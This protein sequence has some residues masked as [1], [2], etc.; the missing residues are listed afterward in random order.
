MSVRALLVTR[1]GKVNLSAGP[2]GG[3][4]HLVQAV[5]LELAKLG[6]VISRALR[7]RLI[8]LPTSTLASEQ[9]WICDTLAA[10]LGANQKHTPLFRKFPDGVPTDTFALWLDK[11][12]A[13]YLQQPNQPC[14]SCGAI[15]STHVLKPCCDVVCEVCF[16]G[17]NYSRCPVCE[18]AVEPGQPFFKPGADFRVLSDA[19]KITFK[20]LDLCEDVDA[21]ARRL[22]QSLLA[23]PQAMNPDDV[24]ALR[25]LVAEY[26]AVVLSWLPEKIPVRENRAHVFGHLMQ[27]QPPLMVLAAAKPHLGTATDILRVLAAY[28]GADPSLQATA[29]AA[30]VTEASRARWSAKSLTTADTMRA[31]YAKNRRWFKVLPDVTVPIQSALFKV[32][33]LSRALRRALLELLESMRPEAVVADMLRHPALWVHLG[34]LLHPFE[35]TKRFPNTARAFAVVRG[36]RG[37]L[38]EA[39]GQPIAEHPDYQRSADGRI[40]FISFN[41]RTSTLI[42]SQDGPALGRHLSARPG[43]LAR[44]LDLALRLSDEAGQAQVAERFRSKLSQ[45][46]TPVLMTLSTGLPQRHKKWPIRVFFPKG[47]EFKAPSGWDKRPRLPEPLTAGLV[48]DIERELLRRV[49]E[50]SPFSV[51]ILDSDLKTVIVPFNERTASPAAVSLPRGSSVAVPEGKLLRLFVHWCEPQGGEATD[52]DLSVALYDDKW[53]HEATCSYY[54]LATNY[55]GRTVSRSSGDMRD[56]P[57]PDGASEFVDVLRD[58][59]LASGLRYAVMVVNAYSGLSFNKLERG[60]AGLMVRDD[61]DGAYFDPRTVQLR[62]NLQGENGT[63]MPLVYDIQESRLFWIDAYSRGDFAFNNVASSNAAISRICP[64]MMSYFGFGV[65]PTMFQLGA[66]HAAAR[67]GRVLVRDSGGAWVFTRRADEGVHAFYRRILSGTPD[68]LLH[69]MP[70]VEAPVFAALCHGDLALPQESAVYALFREQLTEVL[71]ASDLLA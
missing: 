66:M 35:Y 3:D 7:A 59:A 19:E 18:R 5:E 67:C 20:L 71:A 26:R 69:A 40:R 37:P 30:K 12:I 52:I 64:E 34:G 8:S 21:E 56:A 17:S 16:D 29:R 14:L 42:D 1:S 46:A 10:A 39:L 22:F 51:G 54:E 58:E 62:F 68:E 6:Y 32:R 47:N 31:Y 44:R 65:R 70:P 41:S 45:M 63:F 27:T 36:T 28:S 4:P 38:A 60:F 50:K 61:A 55:R 48:A 43:E 49:S 13:Y 57:P 23:R 9:R 53:S 15:G 33:P 11:V 24:A 2:G 25:A